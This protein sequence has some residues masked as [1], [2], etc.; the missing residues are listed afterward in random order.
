MTR[1]ISDAEFIRL[2]RESMSSTRMA[3]ATGISQQSISKRRRNIEKKHDIA[4][5]TVDDRNRKMYAN[6][7]L[8]SEDRVEVKL[9]LRDGVI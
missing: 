7:M 3:A 1:I 2:W 5:P 4:L 8:V 9:E 6:S